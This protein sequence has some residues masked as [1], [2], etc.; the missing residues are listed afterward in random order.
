[1]RC[2]RPFILIGLV[3]VAAFSMLEAGC[4]GGRSSN[5]GVASIGTTTSAGAGAA[6]TSGAS[7]GGEIGQ[8]SSCMRSHGLTTFP[9]PAA[10]GSSAGIRAAKGRIAHIAA[11]EV[12]SATFQ[13]AQRACAKYYG[14]P[15]QP[16]HVS[17]QQIQKLLAVSRCMR[18][19]GIP[20]FPDP[21]PTTGHLGTPA[22]I[23][24][25]SPQILAAL[26]ECSSLGRAAG[27]GTPHTGPQKAAA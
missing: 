1:M 22:G 27:L 24:E 12:S 4:G 13:A 10:F 26:R 16:A 23:D 5:A 8:Y 11:S 25:T 18:A 15:T 7:P 2:S 3:A 19:H 21:N 9:D 6:A 20:D 14:P 17:P